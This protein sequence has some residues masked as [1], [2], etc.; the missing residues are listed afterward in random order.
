MIFQTHKNLHIIT[1]TYCLDLTLFCYIC[2]RS[3]LLKISKYN[4]SSSLQ[5]LLFWKD[6]LHQCY[7]SLVCIYVYMLINNVYNYF[8]TFIIG[9]K[10][11]LHFC[12]FLCSLTIQ[13]YDLRFIHVDT[14]RSSIT[15][16]V[17]QVFHNQFIHSSLDKN[18]GGF[19]LFLL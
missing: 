17:I 5:N 8:K 18:L 2:F 14:C 7:V 12:D 4:Y 9:I 16:T 1:D 15:L 6:L 3:F 13:C 19:H 11:Y 10:L